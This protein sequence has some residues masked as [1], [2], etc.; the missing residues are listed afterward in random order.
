[1][2]NVTYLAHKN[3]A[4]RRLHTCFFERARQMERAAQVA[5][6]EGDGPHAAIHQRAADLWDPAARDVRHLMME[7]QE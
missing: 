2:S 6:D 5:R 3:T 1:M 7:G 4:L